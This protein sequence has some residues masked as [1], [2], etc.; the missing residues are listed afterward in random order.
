VIQYVTGTKD[1]ANV[2]ETLDTSLYK[3]GKI[4]ITPFEG[5]SFEG[6]P[7]VEA[8][9]YYSGWQDFDAN[10]ELTG[11]K[12]V[13]TFDRPMTTSSLSM[14]FD[15]TLGEK[16]QTVR[17]YVQ[18]SPVNNS[19]SSTG[20]T[21]YETASWEDAIK[22][23]ANG[24]YK[25]VTYTSTETENK[26]LTADLTIPAGVYLYATN[27]NLTI[28]KD[29]TLTVCGT[30]STGAYAKFN[31]VV[32]ENGGTIKTNLK[33]ETG[34]YAVGYVIAVDHITVKNGGQI[35]VP[36]GGYIGLRTN[37]VTWEAGSS[38]TAVGKLRVD[39]YVQQD[40]CQVNA[41]GT[42]QVSGS[43]YIEGKLVT[44]G[45]GAMIQVDTSGSSASRINVSGGLE[46][47]IGASIVL[48]NGFLFA[49]GT[50][51]NAGTITVNKGTLYLTNTGFTVTNE[52]TGVIQLG[53]GAAL[54]ISGTVLTNKGQIVRL[55]AYVGTLVAEESVS[56]Y[57]YENGITYVESA[58][59]TADSYDRYQFTGEPEET[60]K[61]LHLTAK[62]V[63][64]DGGTC[65][66]TPVT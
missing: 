59:A 31:S 34:Y 32:V 50:S 65:E 36:T 7:E 16:T 6:T 10:A 17:M 58:T 25:Y 48:N 39:P 12:I 18:Y 54:D 13:I 20:A 61:V 63:N 41:L 1:G 15:I 14:K 40:P 4:V 3:K 8:S 9:Y 5:E 44:S 26:T 23:A 47:G 33:D 64:V 30:D 2:K 56:V 22:Q 42:V 11:E 57:R 66:F 60:A 46:H 38:V 53:S 21:R 49:Y 19:S 24:A 52:S 55:A 27:V 51:V 43:L 29:V 62:L 35:N 37:S 28:P 45:S